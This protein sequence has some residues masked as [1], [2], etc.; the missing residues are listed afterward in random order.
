MLAPRRLG[1]RES[2]LPRSRNGGAVEATLVF[3]RGMRTHSVGRVRS[4]S[5]EIVFA[6]RVLRRVNPIGI[7]SRSVGPPFGH[8]PVRDRHAA[9]SRQSRRSRDQSSGELSGRSLRVGDPGS[10]A[11]CYG[12]REAVG[13]GLEDLRPLLNQWRVNLAPGPWLFS[14]ARGVGRRP[15]SRAAREPR[16]SGV[17]SSAATVR[18]SS[19]RPEAAVRSIGGTDFPRHRGKFAAPAPRFPAIR[20]PAGLRDR[21]ANPRSFRNQ[22]PSEGH[23]ISPTPASGAACG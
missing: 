12:H 19:P 5:F 13:G 8:P 1:E 3:L 10:P 9:G 14:V 18:R 6:T 15:G 23:V 4:S 21:R 2:L 11:V 17:S 16:S 20:G 22:S 7:E